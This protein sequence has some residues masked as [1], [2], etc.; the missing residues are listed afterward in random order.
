LSELKRILLAEDNPED[1]ELSLTALMESNVANQ[2]DV[3]RDGEEALD[4]LYGRGKF[5]ASGPQRPVV[6]LLDLKMPKLG[7]LEVLQCIKADP[8]LKRIPVVMLTSSREEPDLVES[9]RL[10][11]NAY[12]VK[13]VQFQEFV[14]AVK[15]TGR[16]W[17]ILNECSPRRVHESIPGQ[18]QKGCDEAQ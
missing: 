6:V 5:E 7:G 1:V 3:V 14:C 10:G 2:V 18:R 16:F 12:I 8:E 9:Y 11:V 4:Y 13:P 17:A 15:E